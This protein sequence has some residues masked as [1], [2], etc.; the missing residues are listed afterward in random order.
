M[1][2]KTTFSK[3]SSQDVHEMVQELRSRGPS[4]EDCGFAPLVLD[5][6]RQCD[7]AFTVLKV[8]A[9]ILSIQTECSIKN[10]LSSK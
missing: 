5:R 10:G 1:L 9:D 7:E 4:E 3:C 6:V 8:P 2:R